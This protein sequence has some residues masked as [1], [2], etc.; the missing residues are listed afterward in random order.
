V[1]LGSRR[2]QPPCYATELAHRYVAAGRIDAELHKTMIQQRKYWENVLTRVAIIAFLCERGLPLRET[3]SNEIDGF[4]NSVNYLGM[5]ELISQVDLLLFQ[6]IRQHVK[7]GRGHPPYLSETICA[8][9]VTL[10]EV[11][12]VIKK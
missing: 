7:H 9:I 3:G 1:P 11:L 2:H 4:G 5:L 12:D 10:M 6:H 8:K